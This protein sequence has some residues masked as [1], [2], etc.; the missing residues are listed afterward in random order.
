MFKKIV[1]ENQWEAIE[2]KFADKSPAD[3]SKRKS[4]TVRWPDGKVG[5]YKLH[6]RLRVRSYGDMGHT[7]EASSYV[8]FFRIR[9][10][11]VSLEVPIEKVEVDLQGAETAPRSAARTAKRSRPRNPTGTPQSSSA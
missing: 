11:G 5:K 9:V 4:V 10:H 1:A 2:Y 3:F 8:Y 6:S 7:Y